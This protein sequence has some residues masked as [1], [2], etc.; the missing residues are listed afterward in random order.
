MAFVFV[1]YLDDSDAEQ[2]SVLTLAGYAAPLTLWRDFEER[3]SA[4]CTAYKVPILHAKEFHGTKDHFRGWSSVKKNSFIDEFYSIP[5][6]FGISM[7]IR[8]KIYR[9][10]QAET[11]LNK[12]TSSYGAA[13]A[14]MT[15]IIT[16]YSI[17]DKIKRDGL[18][19][20]IESGH[21]NNEEIEKYFHRIKNH[22]LF[23]GVMHT[24]TFSG[25]SESRAIQ[26]A[27]IYAFY[28]RRHAA[29]VDRFK[30]D[31]ALPSERIYGRILD[32]CPHFPTVI[33]NPY[34]GRFE[35]TKDGKPYGETPIS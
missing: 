22:E 14:S 27:D 2:S 4:V 7:S 10:R 6:S 19:F 11:G 30:R 16:N 18:S 9:E 21:N 13:F 32:K 28:S 8:K 24:L 33:T 5:P 29:K 15:S 31:I 34:A 23:S 20:V 12:S 1:C 25:K 26:L 3:A 35:G 17:S